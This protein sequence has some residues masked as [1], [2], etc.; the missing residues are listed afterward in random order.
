MTFIQELHTLPLSHTLV[1]LAVPQFSYINES[2]HNN[3]VTVPKTNIL[4]LCKFLFNISNCLARIQMLW[5]DFSTIH[6]RMAAIQ[7]E[8]IIE[9]SQSLVGIVVTR[10]LNPTVS[11]H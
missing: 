8:G 7:F 2:T 4:L 10:I 11:L 6:D 3:T 9:F 5:A 1:I